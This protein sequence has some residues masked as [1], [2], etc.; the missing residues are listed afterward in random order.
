MEWRV[1][2]Q[3]FCAASAGLAIAIVVGA[4]NPVT[5]QL[6]FGIGAS[7]PSPKVLMCDYP[8]SSREL[9]QAL[10]EQLPSTNYFS[11]STAS[12]VYR[13][14]ITKV[15]LKRSLQELIGCA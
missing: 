13:Q 8:P 11:D 7:I 4:Y 1:N 12:A 10:E 9:V 15:L 3:R 5:S 14:H 6:R 2:Y